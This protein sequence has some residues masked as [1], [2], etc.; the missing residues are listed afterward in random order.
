M[1]DEEYQQRIQ[2]YAKMYTDYLPD[3]VLHNYT[4]GF[5]GTVRDLEFP[6]RNHDAN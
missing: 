3:F 5:I 6:P 4:V 2:T 1:S